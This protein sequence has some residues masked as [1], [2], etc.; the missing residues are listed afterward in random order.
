VPY[1][2]RSWRAIEDT[3]QRTEPWLLPA[4]RRLRD[5]RRAD[6]SASDLTALDARRALRFLAGAQALPAPALGW[7]QN[8]GWHTRQLHDW[9]ARFRGT[10]VE[11][12][13]VDDLSMARHQQLYDPAF[14]ARWRALVLAKIAGISQPGMV[15]DDPA[16]SALRAAADAGLSYESLSPAQRAKWLAP[17]ELA[18]LLP[19]EAMV[20]ILIRSY[21]PPRGLSE[22]VD[23]SA[24]PLITQQAIRSCVAA[25]FATNEATAAR[26][27]RM[28]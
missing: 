20:T 18:G 2:L 26:A 13:F 24:G 21:Q 10:L 1:A 4:L 28:K 16:T 23:V 6:P 25:A 17:G 11:D 22:L 8:P 9:K 7:R 3:T 15:A 27:P 12:I 5:L 19:D 14:P